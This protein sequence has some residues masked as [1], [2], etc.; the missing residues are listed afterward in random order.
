MK[1][2]T[3]KNI[4]IQWILSILF[5][6]VSDAIM[7][8]QYQILGKGM[9]TRN[10]T[11][12]S[13]SNRLYYH[14][15]LEPGI[16]H[17]LERNYKTITTDNNILAF[18]HLLYE[19]QTKTGHTN[20][21]QWKVI[22]NYTHLL[23]LN[24]TTDYKD[25]LLRYGAQPILVLD[26]YPIEQGGNNKNKMMMRRIPQRLILSCKNLFSHNT[27]TRVCT[28]SIKRERI[29]YTM[30]FVCFLIYH[31]LIHKSFLFFFCT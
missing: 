15:R 10:E 17:L 18:L 2:N 23:E 14:S 26:I 28:L 31:F 8:Y 16:R 19:D 24:T 21:W 22:R 6:V 9:I 7:Y 3:N 27:A 29:D 20:H 30:C 12:I 5:K 13:G 25:L 4:D 1:D 11:H